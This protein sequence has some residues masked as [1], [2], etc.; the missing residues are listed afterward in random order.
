MKYGENS[1]VGDLISR[2]Y[3]SKSADFNVTCIPLFSIL[4]AAKMLTVDYFSLD[5]ERAELRVLKTIPFD[6]VFIK[7]FQSL[8]FNSSSS[9]FDMALA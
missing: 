7:V 6:K 5:V 8:Q 1:A 3:I 2:A 9:I 4:K